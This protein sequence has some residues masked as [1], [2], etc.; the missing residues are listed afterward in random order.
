MAIKDTSKKPYIIDRDSNV[1]DGIDLPVRIG[2]DD[3]AIARTST[4]IE[5][6]KNKIR[7]LLQSDA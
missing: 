2:S 5:A 3:G 4:T 1:T 6:V 7:N